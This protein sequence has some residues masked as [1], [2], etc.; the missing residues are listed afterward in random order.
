MA[1]AEWIM[2][3]CSVAFGVALWFI[4]RPAGAATYEWLTV[5][6]A[7]AY[8]DDA[9]NIP[10]AYRDEAVE[11]APGALAEYRQYTHDDAPFVAAPRPAAPAPKASPSIAPAA[12]KCEAATPRREKKHRSTR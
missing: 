7:Y 11:I 6:G 2:F 3:W 8:T 5:D 12:P 10:P 4:G 9:R 1:R